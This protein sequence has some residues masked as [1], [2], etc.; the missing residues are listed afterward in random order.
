LLIVAIGLSGCSEA[1]EPEPLLELSGST[2]GTSYHIKL[3]THS[4]GIP[5][6]AS[7]DDLQ[8]RI[9]QRLETINGMMS[10]Y[11]PDSDLS[12][13]N[14]SD[15]T[16]WIPVPAPLI[17]V[18]ET[19]QTISIMSEGMFDITV[20][21]LVELWGFGPEKHAA[22]PP[23][24]GEIEKT[25]E[26]VGY[27]KLE[28][29]VDPPALRKAVPGLHLDLSAIAKGYAVDQIAELLEQ[30]GFERY[31]VEIGG[32]LRANGSKSGERP[33]R[34]AIERPDPNGRSVQSVIELHDQAMATSGDYRNFFEY[35]GRRYS[36]TI[37][38]TTGQSVRQQ[39][40]SVTVL[41]DECMIADGLAT[42]LLAMGEQA[43]MELAES[44][45][46]AA[47][48]IVRTEDGL[49]VL[50]SSHFLAVLGPNSGLHA[51][52]APAPEAT[53]DPSLDSAD[54]TPTDTSQEP[55]S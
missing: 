25:L 14:T 2:M 39:L 37:D 28:V 53:V 27:K 22:Q 5:E 38:P 50:P 21:P 31:L 40:A 45:E 4:P 26:R 12:L 41:A 23:D 54:E 44:H 13:F 20:G 24:A 15:Q 47:L 6:G 35:E 7:V 51:P 29:R 43:G 34:V 16:D 8:R 36:H 3:V 18:V 11:L 49:Q 52:P 48:F 32:E 42:A 9:D 17:D 19:A 1:P 33:W 55:G 10:T 46:I 30:S